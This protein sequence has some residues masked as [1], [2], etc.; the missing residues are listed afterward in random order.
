MAVRS[1]AQLIAQCQA[2]DDYLN[3][4]EVG[5]LICNVIDSLSPTVIEIDDTDSPYTA[6]DPNG[7]IAADSTSGDITVVLSAV[8]EGAIT[9]IKK[10][11]TSQNTIT[12]DGDGSE[13]IDGDLTTVLTGANRPSI[14]LIGT[15][16]GWVII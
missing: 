13:T 16:G 10:N 6:T 12:V 5:S 9:T 15:T 11:D 8:V 14:T 1:Y 2:L 4:A 7:V 3:A